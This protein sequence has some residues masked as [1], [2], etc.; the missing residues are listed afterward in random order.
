MMMQERYRN[1]ADRRDQAGRKQP[2]K[3]PLHSPFNIAHHPPAPVVTMAK[4]LGDG[5]RSFTKKNY[6]WEIEVDGECPPRTV[7][8]TASPG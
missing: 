7:G 1:R 8:Q 3:T 5:S 2:E 4:D 6:F